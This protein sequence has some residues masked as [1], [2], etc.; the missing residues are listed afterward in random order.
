MKKR[1]MKLSISCKSKGTPPH[2]F[3]LEWKEPQEK[4]VDT[5]NRFR[6]VLEAMAKAHGLM[7]GA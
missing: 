1:T 3:T 5:Y 6:E 2:E 7:R 4:A